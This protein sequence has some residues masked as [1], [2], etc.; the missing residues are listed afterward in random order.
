MA[1]SRQLIKMLDAPQHLEASKQQRTAGV[2]EVQL[3]SPCP[4][5]Q[6]ANLCFTHLD[7]HTVPSIRIWILDSNAKSLAKTEVDVLPLFPDSVISS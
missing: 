1:S 2:S 6:S 3:S 4:L 5:S 7:V